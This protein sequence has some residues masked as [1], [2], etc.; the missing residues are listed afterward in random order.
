MAGYGVI[1][2]CRHSLLYPEKPM[3]R[4][5]KQNKRRER[6]ILSQQL[7]EAAKTKKITVEIR[8]CEVRRPRDKGAKVQ[9]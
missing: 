7:S 1:A 4:I 6:K 3:P 5:Y 8:V 2:H 9:S